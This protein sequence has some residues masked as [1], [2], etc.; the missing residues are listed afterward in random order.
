M[1]ARFNFQFA[2]FNL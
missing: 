2:T 1:T